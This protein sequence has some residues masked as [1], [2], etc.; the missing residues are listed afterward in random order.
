MT[1]SD[2]R[3]RLFLSDIQ[4]N[5]SVPYKAEAGIEEGEVQC[6]YA[7]V[8]DVLPNRV[9]RTTVNDGPV[10]IDHAVGERF[11][12]AQMV[13]TKLHGC[14]VACE[15]RY[16]IEILQRQAP[17]GGPI[18]VANDA[19]VGRDGTHDLDAL[20]G[21]GP[22]ANNIADRPDIIDFA[23][24]SDSTRSRAGMFACTSEMMRMRMSPPSS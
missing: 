8:V 13:S 2:I 1:R 5:V 7:R 4:L 18:M 14:P 12:V 10:L 6:G 24:T 23:A 19:D 20:T 17:N 21:V 22:I 15:A 11:Q 9:T 3:H 16:R